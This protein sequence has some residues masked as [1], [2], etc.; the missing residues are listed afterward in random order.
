M[1]AP[2]PKEFA[3]ANVFSRLGARL[4]SLGVGLLFA[5]AAGGQPLTLNIDRP[6]QIGPAGSTFT[7]QGSIVNNTG[8]PVSTTDLFFNFA[9]FDP[10]FVSPLQLLGDV[11]ATFAN[12][13]TS[14]DLS[15]F[16]IDLAI[17]ALPGAIFPVDVQLQDDA[18]SL[19]APSTVTV[20]VV[21]E[22]SIAALIGLGL[23]SMLLVHTLR[24]L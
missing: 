6:D 1:L 5:V 24:R 9:G 20:A 13:V 4:L 2:V 8:H 18:G 10:G 14:P 21:P 22:P 3:M 7:F 15:L 17:G 16:S 12:G 19:S 23:A 11:P